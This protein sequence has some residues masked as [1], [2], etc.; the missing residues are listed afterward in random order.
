M[1][2]FLKNINLFHN[3]GLEKKRGVLYNLEYIFANE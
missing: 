1:H 2:I 3:I